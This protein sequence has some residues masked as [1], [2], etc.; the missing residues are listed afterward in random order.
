MREGVS[1]EPGNQI[2]RSL[3]QRAAEASWYCARQQTYGSLYRHRHCMRCPDFWYDCV[4]PVWKV[5]RSC[6]FK[7]IAFSALHFCKYFQQIVFS[8]NLFLVDY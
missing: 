4:V 1:M 8:A 7:L 3:P 6:I 5:F 2:Y